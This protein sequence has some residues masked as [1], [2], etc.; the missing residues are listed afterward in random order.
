MSIS[1]DL[2]KNFFFIVGP[3]VI[4]SE[5]LLHTCA[6]K[7]TELKNRYKVP[8]IF[9]SSFDKANRT[10]L[11]S[12]RGPGLKKG[13]AI[14]NKIKKKYQLP[15]ITDIH[16]VHQISQVAKIADFIQIPAF[17]C[18]QTDLLVESAKSNKI[19]SIKKGQ[20]ISAAEVENII[21]KVTPFNDNKIILIER[22]N[23]FGYHNLVVDFSN[24]IK[25]KKYNQLVVLDVTHSTQ[26]PAKLKNKTGGDPEL[27][28]YYSYAAAACGVNGIFLEVH[29]NPKKALSDGPNMLQLNKLDRLVENI[30]AFNKV[31][32]QLKI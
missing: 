16:E 27:I 14:L 25:M 23:F 9:K 12:Y 8:F 3:C 17:L 20:F 30:L 29:P 31:Y 28:P 6:E 19:L 22:G 2:N 21:A 26:K 15:I 5:E 1:T 18:R 10:S 24:L 11:Q 32:R 7:I 4:E 13:L